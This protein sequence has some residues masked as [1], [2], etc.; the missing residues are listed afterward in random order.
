MSPIDLLKQLKAFIEEVTKD[1]ILE[2]KPVK[3]KTTPEY[4][5][6][7]G[8]HD[9]HDVSKPITIISNRA[10]EVFLMQLPDK[11]AETQRVPYILIRFLVGKDDQQT[12][13]I[14]ESECKIRIIAVTYSKD[15]SIGAIDVLNVIIRIRIA[16]LRAG[17]V[18][19][20]LL[21]QPL[22]Y[23]VYENDTSPYHIAEIMLNFE[24]PEIRR[25]V[26]LYES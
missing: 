8:V 2:V 26:Q 3:N 21:R 22:E 7:D 6:G 24:I 18:G 23:I 13:D 17:Q 15:D 10:P 20:F 11:D 25:E 1:I 4:S 12:G 14:P 9:V 5:V 16:L 19:Q